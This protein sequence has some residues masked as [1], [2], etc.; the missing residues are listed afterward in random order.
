M[1][2]ELNTDSFTAWQRV[3]EDQL[4]LRIDSQKGEVAVVVA[5]DAAKM[6]NENGD[7]PCGLGT[8][9][10]RL[11]M[12]APNQSSTDSTAE[13]TISRQRY[14]VNTEPPIHY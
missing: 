12:G 11:G 2:P 5:D 10:L 7:I 4:G 6:P 8:R 13:K 1:Q 9:Q 3:L 14:P